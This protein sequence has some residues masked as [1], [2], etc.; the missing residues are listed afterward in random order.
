MS[1]QILTFEKAEHRY[2]KE[3]DPACR[4][5][6]KEGGKSKWERKRKLNKEN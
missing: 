2:R 1:N 6:K 3:R 4:T 5:V